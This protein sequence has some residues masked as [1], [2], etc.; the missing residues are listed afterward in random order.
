MAHNIAQ[1]L[2][3]PV[4]PECLLLGVKRTSVGCTR[5]IKGRD[6]CLSCVVVCSY[7]GITVSV[8]SIWMRKPERTF[9]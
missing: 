8:P 6:V 9:G 1:W 3:S 4:G 5:A 2:V 7:P